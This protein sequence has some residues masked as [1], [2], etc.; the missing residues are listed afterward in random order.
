AGIAGL[1]KI[2]LSMQKK[3]LPGSI[4]FKKLNPG[5]ELKDSPLNVVYRHQ[6]WNVS[7]DQPRF[8][9]VSSFGSGGANAH[10]VLKEYRQAERS[11]ITQ[12][13]YLFVLSAGNLERLRAYAERILSWLE[14]NQEQINIS[15]FIYTFQA[16]RS[17]ME[18]RLALKVRGFRDLQSKLEQ[19][20]EEEEGLENCWHENSKKAHS[21]FSNLLKGK[22]GQQV[23][24]AALE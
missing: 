21:K 10:V 16:G 6:E 4:H 15:D 9:C 7:E 5:I 23:I 2:V 13:F 17:G 24:D 22:T 18:E 12:D 14:K 20:L 8:G 11:E 1:L 19:W 3:E